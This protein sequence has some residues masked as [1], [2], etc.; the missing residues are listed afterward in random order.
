MSRKQVVYS[1]NG[2]V[3]TALTRMAGS[4]TFWVMAVFILT[5]A[6]RWSRGDITGSDFFQ[7]VQIGVIGILIRSALARAEMAANAANP[8]LNDVKAD[9]REQAFPI[10][11]T[12]GAACFIGT[13]A[14]LALTACTTP[15]A[16]TVMTG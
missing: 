12:G 13:A 4:K 6:D 2:V 11:A 3:S 16:T 10:Q 1:I 9:T 8:G 7:M 5:A 15:A 14:L